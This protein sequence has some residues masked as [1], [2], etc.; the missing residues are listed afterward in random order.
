MNIRIGQ[1]NHLVAEL[2]AFY[3][4]NHPLEITI[5][6]TEPEHQGGVTLSQALKFNHE[7]QDPF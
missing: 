3:G 7:V 5:A 1:L 6:T 4:K 2:N